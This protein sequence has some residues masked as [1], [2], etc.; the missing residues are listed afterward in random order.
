MTIT[1]RQFLRNSGLAAAYLALPGW[2]SAC[3]RDGAPAAA[4]LAQPQTWD[5]PPS[6]AHPEIVHLLNRITYG[7]RPGQVAQ[8]AQ[9]GWD[10]FLAQQ[11]SPETIDDS[12]LDAQLAQFATLTMSSAELFAGYSPTGQPGPRAIV[13]ELEAAALLRAISSE[14]QLFEI[15]VDFWSNH[16][17]IFAGKGQVKWLKT[18]DD[19]DVIRK[20]ALGKFRDLLLASAKSPAMLV[21]LDNAENIRPGAGR[22]PQGPGGLNENYAREV[23]ELHT[24]GAD[25]GYSQDDVTAVAR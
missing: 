3:Q 22:G 20:H 24:V 4:Q 23:M 12:A 14:R 25:G 7:P 15:M 11:L 2:L 9:L 10:A 13:Q 16:L 5:D 19:R 6:G 18:A 8:V 17:N 1:R 21:Y